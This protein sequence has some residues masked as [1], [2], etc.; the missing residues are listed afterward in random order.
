MKPS[1]VGTF[2]TNYKFFEALR[3]RTKD[4]APDKMPTFIVPGT[5][6]TSG[7]AYLG[8]VPIRPVPH[9]EASFTL[10]ELGLIKEV[11]V[12]LSLTAKGRTEDG[13]ETKS[14][15]DR[16]EA[17]F[18]KQPSGKKSF[19]D[20][21]FDSVIEC[22][23]A[24]GDIYPERIPSLHAMFQTQAVAGTFVTVMYVSPFL[25]SA[26]DGELNEGNVKAFR[27]LGNEFFAMPY[28]PAVSSAEEDSVFNSAFAGSVVGGMEIFPP[29][30]FPKPSTPI[31]PLEVTHERRCA[32]MGFAKEIIR[33]AAEAAV[34]L[35]KKDEISTIYN[36]DPSKE[37]TNMQD[38]REGILKKT[39]ETIEQILLDAIA[40]Y[41]TD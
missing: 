38:L 1:S 2:A 16:I 14:L 7:T 21:V 39:S 33:Q 24:Y 18:L 17:N 10:E 28:S 29:S 27:A 32:G 41:G 22:Y 9:V 40:K 8:K 34:R 23:K 26:I 13:K 12:L 31:E 11:D 25:K 6:F 30:I 4:I 19:G 15:A 35:S 37:F 20:A 5:P 36:I 3:Q